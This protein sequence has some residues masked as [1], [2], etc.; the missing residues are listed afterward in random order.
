MCVCPE[1]E[2]EAW[3]CVAWRLTGPSLLRWGRGVTGGNSPTV[4]VLTLFPLV[5]SSRKTRLKIAVC[6]TAVKVRSAMGRKRTFLL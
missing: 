4:A 6:R 2:V 3:C 1:A 5:L